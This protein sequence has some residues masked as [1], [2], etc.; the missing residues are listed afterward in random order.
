[1]KAMTVPPNTYKTVTDIVTKD[2]K[3][4]I[5]LVD[6]SL[7]CGSNIEENFNKTCSYLSLLGRTEYYKTLKNFNFAQRL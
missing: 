7:L 3:D 5:W 6:D 1:M 4:S 2:V